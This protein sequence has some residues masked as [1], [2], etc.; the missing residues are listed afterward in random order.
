[1]D[2][3][4]VIKEYGSYYYAIVFA[5]TF[6]EGETFVIFSGVAAREGILD[7]P[8]LILCAWAGSF[9]GDQLYF[10]IGRRYGARLLVRF[11]RWK[12]GVDHAL[13]LLKKFSTGF[14]LSFRFIYGVRNFSSFA[15]GMSGLSWARFAFLNFIAAGVW[16]TCFAGAGYLAGM[17][18]Q[19]VL[20]DLA[21][22]FGLLM[23][24]AFLIVLVMMIKMSR[25]RPAVP[26]ASTA[27]TPGMPAQAD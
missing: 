20:G 3:L 1:V 8:L 7:L 17:A 22:G 4:E 21:T 9:L 11:P 13:G 16:A 2:V 5:W 14:V 23:L 15:M 25:R 10:L 19:H 6:L 18:L 24:A 27:P 26:A 12:P